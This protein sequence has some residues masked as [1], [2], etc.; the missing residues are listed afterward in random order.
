MKIPT[1]CAACRSVSFCVHHHEILARAG[2][3][4]RRLIRGDIHH[5]GLH[6]LIDRG[7]HVWRRRDPLNYR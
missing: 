5:A 3:R 2:I 6:A 7:L 4:R 1:T